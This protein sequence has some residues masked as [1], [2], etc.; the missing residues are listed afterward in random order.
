MRRIVSRASNRATNVRRPSRVGTPRARHA[1]LLVALLL[2]ATGVTGGLLASSSQADVVTASV[3]NLRNGW[4]PHETTGAL[5]PGALSHGLG[6]LFAAQVDGQVYAQPV[7]VGHTVIVA[8]E[9]DWVYS[10]DAVTGDVIWKKFLPGLVNRKSPGTPWPASAEDCTDLAPE[11]G[12][13]GT[14]V[15]NP[16][17]GDVYMV[18]L[19]V[20]AGNSA[21]HPA[22]YLHALNARTGVERPGWPVLIHGAPTNDPTR[23]FNSFTQLQ[24]PGLLLLSGSVYAGFGS[25]CDYAPYDGYV[26]GVNITKRTQTMWTD[27]AGLTS[28][29]AGIWQSGAGLMSDG[30]GRIFLATGPGGLPGPEPGDRPPSELAMAVVRLAVQP[31]GS[32]VA[33]DFFSPANA[34]VLNRKDGDVGSGGPVGLPFGTAKLPHLL[35]QAGKYDGIFVLNREHLGGRAQGPGGTNAVVSNASPNLRGEWGHPAAF[36]DTAV[37]SARNV[38]AS[39]DYVYYVGD[40]DSLRYF[41]ATLGGKNGVTPKLSDVA[42]SSDIFHFGSGSPVVTSDGTNAS[43]AVVWVDNVL[44]KAGTTEDL[45]AFPA[46]PP[47]PGTGSCS[48]ATPCT[49]SPIWTSAPFSGSGKFNIAATDSGRVYLGSRGVPSNGTNCPGVPSGN[50]CGVVYGFGT[51]PLGGTALPSFGY[52]KVGTQSSAATATVQNTRSSGAVTIDSVTAAGPFQVA[53]PYE[54]TPSGGSAAPQTLPVTLHPGDSLT[55]EGVTFNPAAAGGASG[56]LAFHTNSASFPVV[57]LGLSGFGE[58]SGFFTSAASVKFG[59]VPAGTASP[60]QVTVTNGEPV[61]QTLNVGT[62][63]APFG[64]SGA[65]ASQVQPGQS[66]PLTITYSPA[67][68]SE[69]DNATL[70]LPGSSIALSGTGVADKSALTARPAAIK[71]G[72]VRL[73][74]QASAVIDVSNTGNLPAVVTATTSPALPFG[75]PDQVAAGLSVNPGDDLKIPVTLTP[76][77]VGSVSGEYH[78]TWTDVKGTHQLSVRVSGRAAAPAAGIALPPPGGGWTYNGSATLTGRDLS[79]TGLSGNQAGSAVYS[80]PVPSN[81]LKAKFTTSI[82]GGTGGDGM[83]FALLSAQTK[84]TALGQPAGQLGFGGLPGVAVTL[85]TAQDGPGYPSANFV[86]IATSGRAGNLKFVAT[87]TKV[88]NL[89]A[90]RHLVSLSVSGRT[91]TV[92]VDGHKVLATAVTLPRSVRL[93]FTGAT[94]TQTD[95]HVFSGFAITAGGHR[96]PGPG[97]GWSFNGDATTAGSDTAVTPGLAPDEAGSVVYSTPVTTAG[98]KVT[99]NAQFTGAGGDGLTFAMLNPAATKD[100]WL[101]GSGLWLGLGQK[102]AGVP[103]VGVVVGTANQ[104]GASDPPDFIAMTVKTTPADG[105]EFGQTAK[106]LGSLTIGTDTVSVAV[107]RGGS[108]GLIVTIRLNGV[109]VLQT[110]EPKLTPT[111]R[112]AFTA[113]TGATAD[114]QVVRTIAVSAKS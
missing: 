91:I 108:L 28:W 26:V 103:G 59:S 57:S 42:N 71:L 18:S 90:G 24:R 82:G 105:L 67:S 52:V 23:P 93:A 107:T 53:G 98:L 27:E 97:G 44:D 45:E 79:L 73:G 110:A 60:K 63:N 83:T 3:N 102:V 104:E 7:V 96:I 65:P 49:V 86:G 54:Y 109:Q 72:L 10:L 92:T 1:E 114:Q 40:G 15:Y 35:V 39:H 66:V 69:S 5:T 31:N 106:G 33:K 77:S 20:P 111:V 16:A 32:L 81:G 11:N 70:T 78:L 38:A 76:T 58:Q 100:G 30:P 9:D 84:Q 22:Y 56:S 74:H 8:T 89:R 48:A 113:G 4:D 47:P 37:L 95:D 101:G 68:G 25:R 36:A 88:P 14:P 62:L 2:A 41:K 75:T 43:T 6:Q 51:A 17:N 61:A 50:Y 85:D 80:V 64:V 55:A 12:V 34:N 112:L 13:T 99:F 94:S 19:E 29:D 87:T 46:V 21:L